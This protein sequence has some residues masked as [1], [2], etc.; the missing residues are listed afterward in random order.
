M[1]EADFWSLDPVLL[2]SDG[3]GVLARRVLD[4]YIRAEQ[5]TQ[6]T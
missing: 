1:G 5:A 4:Q 6:T 3:G 2:A